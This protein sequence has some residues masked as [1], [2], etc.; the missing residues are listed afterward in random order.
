MT[1]AS[2]FTIFIHSVLHA[3]SFV[4]WL[5]LPRQFLRMCRRNWRKPKIAD[6]TGVEL[7]GG[8]LLIRTLVVRRVLRRSAGRRRA[9]RGRVAAAVGGGVARNAALGLD[10]RVASI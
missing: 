2:A 9:V 6:S 4:D 5:T 1:S 3:H 8:E 7:T 10:R